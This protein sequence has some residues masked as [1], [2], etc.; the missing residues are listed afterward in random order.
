MHQRAQRKRVRSSVLW[1]W[2]FSYG[3]ILLIPVLTFHYSS[4]FTMKILQQTVA[5]AYFQSLRTQS[6]VCE[7]QLSELLSLS[8]FSLSIKEMEAMRK[9]EA[10]TPG[11]YQAAVTVKDALGEFSS[12]LEAEMNVMIVFP[13]QQYILSKDTGNDPYA[14]YMNRAMDG[15][16]VPYDKWLEALGA[17]YPGVFLVS[18]QYSTSSN[19]QAIVYAQTFYRGQ[20]QI[21]VFATLPLEELL[22]A[23]NDQSRF[24]LVNAQGQIAASSSLAL[25][26]LPMPANQ[27]E[28]FSLSVHDE[29]N[30]YVYIGLRSLQ[31]GWYY[32]MLIN[33]QEYWA[34]LRNVQVQMYIG[35]LICVLLGVLLIYFFLK[36]NY[37][38][39]RNLVNQYA[40]DYSA[41]NELSAI[42][43]SMDRMAG[44]N[45]SLRSTLKLH[46]QMLQSQCLISFLQGNPVLPENVA[47][48]EKDRY[49][50]V[51]IYTNKSLELEIDE[52]FGAYRIEQIEDE[53]YV[54]LLHE[55]AELAERWREQSA[56]LFSALAKR[57][58]GMIVYCTDA[59]PF[60]ELPQRYGDMRDTRSD[61]V[62]AGEFRALR[63][64]SLPEQHKRFEAAKAQALKPLL[65]AVQAGNAKKCVQLLEELLNRC[66]PVSQK[67]LSMLRLVLVS[68]SNPLIALCAEKASSPAQRDALMQQVDM[69]LFAN[70]RGELSETMYRLF[71][72][73][74]GIFSGT[75]TITGQEEGLEEHVLV[76]EAKAYVQQHYMD[77][78]LDVNAIAMALN[79]N[80][81]YL[82]HA[83]STQTEGLLSN[84]ISQTRIEH[85]CRLLDSAQLSQDELA[86]RV[87]FS[88]A[89]TFRRAF[90]KHRG[91]LPS[92]YKR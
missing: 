20:G 51:S 80:P 40:I 39:I 81:K 46:A 73:A 66:E 2:F 59:I 22:P 17:N 23:Q 90:L 12:S 11:F 37:R 6:G 56:M 49:Y 7:R 84:Y 38:P 78:N 53:A 8:R 54:L 77:P 76:R 14:L 58:E 69:L 79:R 61:L 30:A 55:R 88:N 71:S 27:E 70:T 48:F 19:K 52:L 41:T 62:K 92:Q 85:A 91:I 32:C 36:R 83:F 31:S 26:D 1:K 68:L 47:D 82:S 5:D 43:A 33:E 9:A 75:E 13:R 50:L 87:G 67:A 89:R 45:E 15:L 65:E 28:S 24:F 35:L 64:D 57:C 34:S 86:E 10:C 3:I 16:D 4:T 18:G 60:A 72:L 44:E 25:P 74:S 63:V 29:K 21:N 42:A